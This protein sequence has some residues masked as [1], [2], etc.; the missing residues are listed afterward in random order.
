M[1]PID[2]RT[3]ELAN[4]GLRI[5]KA[6]VRTHDS[7]TPSLEDYKASLAVALASVLEMLSGV[8]C[9]L[10]RQ[11]G[12]DESAVNLYDEADC[13]QDP[14]AK[15]RKYLD[16]CSHLVASASSD[17]PSPLPFTMMYIRAQTLMHDLRG[18]A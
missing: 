3:S 5:A 16:A 4:E 9:E 7:M 8:F 12:S 18:N 10:S 2:L 15:T 1:S 13:D 17:I 6:L 11:Q 14:V